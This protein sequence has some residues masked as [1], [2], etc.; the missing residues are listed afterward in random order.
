MRDDKD[1]EQNYPT[2]DLELAAVVHAPK[3]WRHYPIGNKCE[4]Y[5]DHKSL[6]YI[7]TQTRPRIRGNASTNLGRTNKARPEGD[8]EIR[9]QFGASVPGRLTGLRVDEKGTLWF[10]NRIRVPK[11]GVTVKIVMEEAHNSAYSIH[12]GSTKMYPDLKTDYRWKGM[13]ADIARYVARCDVCRES[14]SEHRNQQI[15][16]NPYPSLCGNGMR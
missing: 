8:G 1:H 16:C 15:Y 12:P 6:K 13:K 10:K 3:V 4:V 7:F 9:R 5:T 14:K 11:T 2:H